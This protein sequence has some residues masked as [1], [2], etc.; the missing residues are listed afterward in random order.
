MDYTHFGLSIVHSGKRI[1]LTQR[2][3]GPEETRAVLWSSGPL[4]EA[5]SSC[6]NARPIGGNGMRLPLPFLRVD[7][8]VHLDQEHVVGLRPEERRPVAAE[9]EV[10]DAVRE[11]LAHLAPGQEERR[12]LPPLPTQHRVPAQRAQVEV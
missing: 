9:A 11:V 1:G 3:R 10:A 8:V 2:T 4:G 7:P 6:R 12:A 5:F